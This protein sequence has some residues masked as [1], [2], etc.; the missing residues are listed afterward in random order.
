MKALFSRFLMIATIIGVFTACSSEKENYLSSLPGQS[1][2]VFKL[3]TA[4]QWVNRF[5]PLIS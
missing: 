4:P 3:N 1:A 5:D 2:I